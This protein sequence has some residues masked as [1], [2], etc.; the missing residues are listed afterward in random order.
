MLYVTSII[1]ML[2]VTFI[3]V[4]L[5]VV[6]LSVAFFIVMVSVV[7]LS[8]VMLSVVTLSVVMLSVVMLSVVMLSVIMPSVFMLVDLVPSLNQQ[9]GLSYINFTTVIYALV[10]LSNCDLVKISFK[11][12]RLIVFGGRRFWSF[13]NFGIEHK[14]FFFYILNKFEL[15][16]P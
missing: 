7:M 5:S 2:S 11:K 13:L 16:K 15:F 4:M 3:I 14:L 9:Q 1:V 10:L 12:F 6:M 8:V